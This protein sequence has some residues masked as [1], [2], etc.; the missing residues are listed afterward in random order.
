V[1]DTMTQSYLPVTSQ[2]SGAAVEAV[3]DRKTYS[4]MA[5]AAETIGAINSGRI[6]RLKFSTNCY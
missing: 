3:V 6:I 4:L 2:M 5:I 1:T